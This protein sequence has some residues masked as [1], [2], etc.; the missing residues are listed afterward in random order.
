MKKYSGKKKKYSP[1]T[2]AVSG[3][4]LLVLLVFL[5]AGF[6][7]VRHIIRSGGDNFY[8]PYL[9]AASGKNAVRDKALLLRS[10][11]ELAGMVEHLSRSNRELVLENS[12]A[13]VLIEEN[14]KLRIMLDVSRRQ[15]DE[16]IVAE[17]LLRDPLRYREFLTIGKGTKH[18]V[19]PGAAVVDVSPY[20]RLLLVGIVSE[21]SARSSKVITIMDPSLHV[22]GRVGANGMIGFTNTGSMSR[23]NVGR[24]KIGMLPLRDDY[25][26]GGAVTTAGFEKGIPE[27][28]KIGELYFS[29]TP[30]SGFGETDFHCEL[31]PAVKFENLRFVAV[32]IPSGIED[33]AR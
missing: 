26:S 24:I 6:R 11:A 9:K 18:G 28:I 10:P 7:V 1:R 29:G 12:S 27:G 2:L 3:V 5:T 15:K 19:T 4:C 8:Y 20:G 13:A 17:I 32:V 25:V 14:R 30:R 16:F 22:S 33:A 21:C 23:P 31:T